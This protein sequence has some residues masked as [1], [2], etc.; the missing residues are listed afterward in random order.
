MRETGY[1][2]L[3]LAGGVSANRRLR[4]RMGVMMRKEGG[5]AFYPRPELCTDNGAMI[6][7]A[8]W[9]RLRGGQ[10]ADL[11]FQPIARWP[12]D[13]LPPIEEDLVA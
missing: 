4:E 11:A 1:K 7:F 2:R 10:K 6:A 3:I 13:S 12:L 9:Q 5:D 8:A